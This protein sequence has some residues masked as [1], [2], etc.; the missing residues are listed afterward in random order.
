MHLFLFL[1]F[2]SKSQNN[3]ENIVDDSYIELKI[4]GQGN[5]RLYYINETNKNCQGLIPPDKIQINNDEPIQNPGMIYNLTNEESNIKLIWIDKN[6]TT[7]HCLFNICDN[8]TYI[9]FSHFNSRFVTS[10]AGLFFSCKSLISVNFNNF[11]SSKVTEMHNLFYH[12]H[13]LKSIDLSN[14][15]TSNVKRMDKL[16]YRCFSLEFINISS[17][18]DTSNVINM[19]RMFCD[20]TLLIS[21]NLSNFNTSN[22]LN[23]DHMFTNCWTLTSLDL[24]NFDTSKVTT[25]NC[26][27][28]NCWNLTNLNLSTFDTSN[29]TDFFK[30]FQD[31]ISIESINLSGF[32]TSKV[33]N[34]S[35]MFENCKQ[36]KS[37][38]LSHFNTHN[39]QSMNSMFSNCEN[40]ISID[41]SD[42]DTSKV[43][44]FSHMF[45]NCKSLKSINLS[46][47]NTSELMITSD[48]FDGCQE[49]TY[50]DISNFDMTK[51]TI[52]SLMFQNCKNL[53]SVNFP[54][55]KAPN[56]YKL[57]SMFKNCESLISVD[58][59]NFITTNVIYMDAMFLNCKSLTSINLSNFDTTNMMWINSMFNGCI[60]LE[61]INLKNVIETNKTEN[62]NDVF[63]DTPEN[64]VIC[65]DETKSPNLTNL[66]REKSCYT[67]YCEDDWIKHQKK[68]IKGNN[69]CL[70]NCSSTYEFNNKCYNSCDYGFYYDKENPQQK[71]CK[72]RSDKCLLCSEVEIIKNLCI[73][74]NDLYYPIENDPK[75]ILPYIN[76]YKEPEGYY[77]DNNL[78]K[79]CY[80]TCKSCNIKGDNIKHNCLECKDN[81]IFKLEYEGAFNCLENCSYFYFEENGNYYC[82]NNSFCPDEYNKLIPEESK[83]INNC[84]L[85]ESYKYEFRNICYS[86]CPKGLKETKENYCEAFCNE[87]NPFVIIDTQECVEF[88]DLNLFFEGLCIYKYIIE[89]KEGNDEINNDQVKKLQ[90]IKM[91]NKIIENAEKGVTSEKFDTTN[92]ERGKDAIY[93]NEKLTITLTTTE[94]QKKPNSENGKTTTIDLGECEDLL[95][96]V[97]NISDDQKIFIKKIDVIQDGYKIPYVKYDVYSK[98]NGSNLVKLNLTVCKNTKVD[99]SIPIDITDSL[100]KLNPNSDYYNDVCYASSSESGTDIILKDRK[101][102]FIQENKT[103]CQDGCDFSDYDFKYKKVLCSCD[104]KEYSN[105]Y[106]DMNI[107]KEKILKNFIDIKNIANINILK[108]Y[109]SLFSKKG[110]KNNVGSFSIILIFLFHIIFI[111]IFYYNQLDKIKFK[112][113]DIMVGIKNWKTYKKIKREKIKKEKLDKNVSHNDVD[114][115]LS[116]QI[117][118][119]KDIKFGFYKKKKHLNKMEKNKN[120]NNNIINMNN[121]LTENSKNKIISINEVDIFEKTKEI[122]KFK[123]QELNEMDFR[124]ALKLDKRNFCQFYLSLIK[125]KHDLIFSF[126]YNDDYNSK[127]IKI[128]LFF[129]SFAMNFTINTLFFND[130]TM[131]KIYV[132]KG[133]F[134]ILF[135]LPQIIYSSIISQIL[136][137]LFQ[138]LALSEDLILEFKHNKKSIDVLERKIKLLNRLKFKFILFFIIS[139]IFLLMFWY[140][141]SMFCAIYMNTQIHL[142]KDTLISF[143]MSLIY[144]FGIYLLP[145]IFRFAALSNRN[146]KTKRN[147]TRKFLF[148]FSKFLQFC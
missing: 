140:Y 3:N 63:K 70:D 88:C 13:S 76:C 66:I 111:F 72:C 81:F 69:I 17:K 45:K 80:Y 95:R 116:Q 49:L 132:D 115:G 48:M 59:S 4:K 110:F 134:E 125:T 60:N 91:Q 37:I 96:Q 32:N 105:N 15:D 74:C 94:N 27:F 100:D 133:K 8:I 33:T 102:E 137:S 85:A 58:L 118:K 90:E 20:C 55:T 136:Y 73:S 92:I 38:N 36:L 122:M 143:L 40:L 10:I 44:T 54:K 141:I 30:M 106:A 142:I 101:E 130:D 52:M 75:N 97:Y 93:E 18:F 129:I 31:C 51:L 11:D 119:N 87:T 120:K 139:T 56:L 84:S 77:L 16:F 6:I 25:M 82:T 1:Q 64:L 19:N 34:M 124:P 103:V 131:H 104:V 39:V 12:C 121:V 126:C 53:I 29:V 114:E 144:S 14:F 109:K 26:M 28:Y 107:D 23:M 127:F 46:N 62:T 117:K 113:N 9:D 148:L 21:L 98:L 112:I 65:L 50:I 43:T 68:L 145:A 128:D 41:I 71:K 79:E 2:I 146:K 89:I 24:F 5:T 138:L 83:C 35:N 108:C 123:E 78:Y 7:L 135:Q 57:G 22:V 67:I 42:F 99:I 61:Y 147:K 86:K 47:L